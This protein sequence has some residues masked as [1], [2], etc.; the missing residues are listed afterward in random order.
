MTGVIFVD[1]I[2]AKYVIH[3]RLIFAFRRMTAT[4]CGRE[5]VFGNV[6]FAVD[7]SSYNSRDLVARHMNRLAY[8]TI[9]EVFPVERINCL[10]LRGSHCFDSIRRLYQYLTIFL[11]PFLPMQSHNMASIFFASV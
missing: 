3:A 5:L 4:I 9:R 1:T 6:F 7:V 8:G 10:E 2:W 11:R